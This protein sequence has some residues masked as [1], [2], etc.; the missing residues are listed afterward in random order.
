MTYAK[1]SL[2]VLEFGLISQQHLKTIIIVCKQ[3]T[4]IPLDIITFYKICFLCESE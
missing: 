4:T 3:K 2:F 1:G